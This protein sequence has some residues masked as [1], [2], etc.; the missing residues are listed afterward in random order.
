MAAMH[1][2]RSSYA[3]AAAA[4]LTIEILIALFVRDA[5]VRPYLGDSLAMV[6]VYLALRAVTP[7]RTAAAI[8]V[9]LAVAIA[10]ELGQLFGLLGVLGLAGNS[11][12]RVLLGTGFEPW[13]FVAYAAGGVAALAMEGFRSRRT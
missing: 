7:M 4:V 10:V 3:F 9:A 2:V 8:A 13:D 12:A 11:F 6:L 1:N 5:L